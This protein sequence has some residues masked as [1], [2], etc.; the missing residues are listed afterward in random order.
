MLPLGRL[1]LLLPRPWPTLPTLERRP[2]LNCDDGQGLLGK[3]LLL[4]LL[5]KELLL[6]LK[7]E[8]GE[9]GLL[10]KVTASP[11]GWVGSLGAASTDCLVATRLAARVG[12]G[13]GVEVDQVLCA[14]EVVGVQVCTWP[15]A[16]AGV[17]VGPGPGLTEATVPGHLFLSLQAGEGHWNVLNADLSELDLS[18]SLVPVSPQLLG[19]GS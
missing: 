8:E 1:G 5:L 10:E 7:E 13:L 14:Q 17:G 2:E 16:G 4:L 19:L 3:E 11:R 6:L 18:D 12:A 15:G 9:E